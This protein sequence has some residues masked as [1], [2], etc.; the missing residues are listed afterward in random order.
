MG[1]VKVGINGSGQLCPSHTGFAGDGCVPQRL[2]P[3]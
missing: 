3:G 1:K 2:K